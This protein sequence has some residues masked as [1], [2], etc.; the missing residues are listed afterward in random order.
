MGPWCQNFPPQTQPYLKIA[1]P[2]FLELA[3]AA[4]SFSVLWG[5]KGLRTLLWAGA[6]ISHFQ[7]CLQNADSGAPHGQLSTFG[8]ECVFFYTS[9][10]NFINERPSP[11]CRFWSL[12]WPVL[13]FGSFPAADKVF[14]RR[15]V[16]MATQA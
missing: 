2:S 13:V 16:K 7:D 9:G 11:K 15:N 3:E 10:T 5:G 14:I 8:L 4:K 6:N 1:I 12:T